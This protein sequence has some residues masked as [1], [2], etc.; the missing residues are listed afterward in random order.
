MA[1]VHIPKRQD[2]K[3]ELIFITSRS[4][5]P[6]GQ[7]VNK[8]NSR[9]TLKLDVL[10]S[11]VLSPTQKEVILKRLASRISNDGI[12]AINAQDSRSQMQNREA[13]TLKLEQL[14]KRAFTPL[15]TRRATKPGKA[16]RQKRTK[17]KKLHSEKKKWRQKP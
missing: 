16:A 8:V 2:F 7:N 9:V 4:S 14:L 5:G 13:A 6:G 17:E 1:S 12:L 11:T 15:K 10:R 3:H